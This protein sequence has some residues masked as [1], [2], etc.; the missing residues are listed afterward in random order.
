LLKRLPGTPIVRHDKEWGMVYSPAAP[1]EILQTK[2]IDFPMM[3]R[4]RRFSRYWDLVANSGNFVRSTPLIWGRNRRS[5]R[6][7]NGA[8]GCLPRREQP[9]GSHWG[10]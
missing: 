8:I 10:T 7:C 5:N 2:L 6:S 9:I 1:F 4:L 3:Q